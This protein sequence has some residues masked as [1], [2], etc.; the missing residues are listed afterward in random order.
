MAAEEKNK[1]IFPDF[2][3]AV[4]SKNIRTLSEAEDIYRQMLLDTKTDYNV[5]Y[6][7]KLLEMQKAFYRRFK[8][9]IQ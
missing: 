6:S 4:C 8:Y 3:L 2:N 1:L 9:K 5:L 7:N